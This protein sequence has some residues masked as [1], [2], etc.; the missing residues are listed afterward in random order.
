M[1]DWG[2]RGGWRYCLEDGALRGDSRAM[3]GNVL[4]VE[5]TKAEG[6][7]ARKRGKGFQGNLVGT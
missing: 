3:H 6:R 4:Y 7:G 2:L 5:E 1:V